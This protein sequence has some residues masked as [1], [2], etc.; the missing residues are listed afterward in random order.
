MSD[1]TKSNRPF[2]LLVYGATGYT[3]KKVAQYAIDKYPTLKVAIA[4]RSKEKLIAVAEELGLDE[5]SVLVASLITGSG[6]N[7]N[8]KGAVSNPELIDIVGKAKVVLACAG[9]YRQCGMPL[10]KAAVQAGTDYLDLCGEPQFFEDTLVEC[11]EEAKKNNVLVV[12]A[13]AFDCVPAE[14]S[15]TL[16]ACEVKKRFE[17]SVVSGIEICHTF[18]NIAKGNV[19]TFHAAVDGFHSASNGDLKKSRD[20]VAKKF[21]IEKAPKRP[22]EWP[23]LPKQPGNMPAYHKTS[24]SYALKFPGADAAGKE[25][26]STL[27]LR[28]D[29]ASI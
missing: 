15:A 20:R 14:L 11:E 18:H 10:V 1:Y 22:D 5:S 13:C 17:T 29:G 7:E 6:Q 12:S 24:N 25:Y 3:G 26:N 27:R 9:P 21:G 16:I 19:T 8:D 2:D 28:L 23:K 4:G